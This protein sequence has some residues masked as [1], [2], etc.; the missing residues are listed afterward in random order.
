MSSKKRKR[1]S[2]TSE[3]KK[4]KKV[5]TSYYKYDELKKEFQKV[6]RSEWLIYIII[7]QCKRFTYCGISNHFIRR[8]RRHNQLLKQGARYTAMSGTVSDWTKL[9]WTPVCVVSGWELQKVK[10]NFRRVE[11]LM[12]HPRSPDFQ[13]WRR[14]LIN[15]IYKECSLPSLGARYGI[16]FR[17]ICLR[18][19]LIE[20]K[21]QNDALQVTWLQPEFRIAKIWED[22]SFPEIQSPLSLFQ[23]VVLEWRNRHEDKIKMQQ[24]LSTGETNVANTN[25]SSHSSSSNE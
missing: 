18:Y 4:K 1:N 16:V 25:V 6:T 10:E 5:P 24:T 21:K 22:A 3:S 11:A 19:F 12:H 14:Q 20:A 17:L 23:P 13:N 7:S 8:L 2:K 9:K 15:R